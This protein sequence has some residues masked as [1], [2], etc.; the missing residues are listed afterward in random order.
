MK[1]IKYN[2][3]LPS[4]GTLIDV[5]HPLDYI[6]NPTKNSINIYADKLLINYKTI[7]NKNKKY[8]IICN[9]GVLSSRVVAILRYYGYDV[10]QV[11][12]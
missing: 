4:M 5:Q 12:K 7:L 3:Y 8:F 10:V 1:R 11:I 9:K 6:N 2:D